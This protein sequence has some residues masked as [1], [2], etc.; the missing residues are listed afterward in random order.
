MYQA[1][2]RVLILGCTTNRERMRK[3]M[4]TLVALRCV[5]TAALAVSEMVPVA[6]MGIALY[7]NSAESHQDQVEP[8]SPCSA[9]KTSLKVLAFSKD[10]AV[11][12][13]S[14]SFADVA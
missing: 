3:I 4:M 8:A 13:G 2:S 14:V 5:L 10:D 12:E 9:A 6:M 11:Q 7:Y 1:E